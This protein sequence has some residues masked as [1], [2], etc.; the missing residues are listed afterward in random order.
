MAS[1][2][3]PALPLFSVV[4]LDMV[5][6][7]IAY[8]VLAPLFLEDSGILPPE[9]SFQ[10]RAL[11]LGVLISAYPVSQ[12]FGAPVLGG[13]SDHYGRKKLLLV[14]LAGTVAGYIMFAAGI[15]Y[16][17]LPLMFLGRIIDG[18]TGGNISIALSS[19]ADISDERSKARNFGLIGMAFGLGFIIGPYI[20]GKLADPAIVPWFGYWTPFAFAA[21]LGALNMAF[22]ASG[23]RETLRARVKTPVSLGMGFRNMARAASIPSLRVMFLVL[24]LYSFGFNI[25]TQFF[26]V[27]LVEKFSFSQS[28]IGDMFAYMGFWAAITQGVLTRQVA[29]FLLPR[30]VLSFSLALLG[31]SVAAVMFQETP[32]GL[33]LVIPFI[34]A[35]QGLS[36]PNASALVSNLSAKDS[37]GEIL[38]ITQSI[39]SLAQAVPPLVAG[40]IISFDIHLPVIASCLIILVAWGV[41]ALAF[42]PAR[43]VFHEV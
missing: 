17:S 29:R 32:S 27:L 42:R 9:A 20:G 41:F 11:M 18:F 8:P 23:Y 34:A 39:Q 16:G 28:Q 40:I 13:L 10:F 26:N 2:K 31:L 19:M 24:F 35:F 36:F 21:L 14:S 3:D 33:L 12:F 43:E 37:Q 6:I 30:Q 4:F 38:G 1:P 25:Y 15:V 5:G 7:G 22:L